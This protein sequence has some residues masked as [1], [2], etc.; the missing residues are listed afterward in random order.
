MSLKMPHPCVVGSYFSMIYANPEPEPQ[1]YRRPKAGQ[2]LWVP[3]VCVHCMV[4][5]SFAFCRNTQQ[6]TPEKSEKSGP[7]LN[8]GAA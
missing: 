5:F 4:G 1:P 7:D 2:Y 6:R 8:H 3:C